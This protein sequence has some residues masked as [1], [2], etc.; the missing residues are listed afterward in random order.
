[1]DDSFEYAALAEYL[2]SAIG[3]LSDVPAFDGL[4]GPKQLFFNDLVVTAM[5]F[6]GADNSITDEEVSLL[7]HLMPSTG[8]FNDAK[9][10]VRH[11]ARLRELL[12]KMYQEN[13]ETYGGNQVPRSVLALA[14]YDRRNG[15]QYAEI[16]KEMFY[17]LAEAVVGS[18]RNLGQ[19]EQAS[20][21]AFRAAL[22]APD[23]PASAQRDQ[24]TSPINEESG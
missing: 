9:I 5:R 22:W 15:T 14:N 7:W 11:L 3:E 24:P 12:Q 2:R 16:A 18:D 19:S 17:R 10:S 21:E 23:A 1:M 8:V 6:S 13:L 20:L 4:P